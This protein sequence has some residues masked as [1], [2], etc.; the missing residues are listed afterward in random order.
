MSRA[1]TDFTNAAGALV[2]ELYDKAGED[3]ATLPGKIE[4]FLKQGG[5]LRL[6]FTMDF[7]NM[8]TAIEFS[9]VSEDGDSQGICRLE[10]GAPNGASVN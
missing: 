9:A 4:Q 8:D 5:K 6:A 2:M 10:P 7:V 1:C 3:D